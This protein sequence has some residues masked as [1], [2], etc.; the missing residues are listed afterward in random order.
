MATK[1]TLKQVGGCALGDYL[2][3]GITLTL[4]LTLANFFRSQPP[5]VGAITL[6]EVGTKTT[7][8]YTLSAFCSSRLENGQTQ[9]IL[10]SSKGETVKVQGKLCPTSY[11]NAT[12]TIQGN[13]V[14]LVQF[15]RVEAPGSVREITS[16]ED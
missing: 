9:T 8:T 3:F 11:G 4:L 13:Q 14:Y 7:G 5:Q 2:V 10:S 1:P 15:F 16:L 12:I 6:P